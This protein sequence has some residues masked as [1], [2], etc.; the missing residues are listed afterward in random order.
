MYDLENL[1]SRSDSQPNCATV[2]NLPLDNVPTEKSNVAAEYSGTLL[3]P[4]AGL[5]VP[6]IAQKWPPRRPCWMTKL[7]TLGHYQHQ[8]S[9]PKS[10]RTK[11]AQRE[12]VVH[13]RSEA[14]Q[15]IARPR[16]GHD[17]AL[18]QVDPA[19]TLGKEIKLGESGE[20][21]IPH[22]FSKRHSLCLI[23]ATCPRL[24]RTLIRQCASCIDAAQVATQDTLDNT[25]NVSYIS[26][27][28]L[29]LINMD[30]SGVVLC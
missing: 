7:H 4:G 20:D 18:K 5:D 27:W 19:V 22:T 30:Y 17:C 8:C 24:K 23:Q 9:A 11:R 28:S 21:N 2:T 1:T 13:R 6:P 29:T 16:E 14:N 25:N 3:E 12:F 26:N 15:N 10:L